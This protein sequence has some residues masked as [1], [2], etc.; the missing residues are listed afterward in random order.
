MEV[1]ENQRY[2]RPHRGRNSTTQDKGKSPMEE[3]EPSKKARVRAK[4]RKIGMEDFFL[5]EGNDPY[6]LLD[7]LKEKKADITYGQLMQL[8]SSVR[9]Q[10]HEVA[11]VHRVK[12]KDPKLHV[13]QMTCVADI[14]PLVADVWIQDRQVQKAYVDGGAQVCVTTESTMHHLKVIGKSLFSVRMANSERVK[15]LGVVKDLDVNVLGHKATM[16]IHVMPAK[17]GSY[18]IILGRPWLIATK[19][20]RDWYR[21]YLDLFVDHPKG[22]T[23]RYNMKIG[24]VVEIEED[25][26]SESLGKEDLSTSN[27]IDYDSEEEAYDQSLL[28]LDADVCFLQ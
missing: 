13:V 9:R 2:A 10:W 23:I 1:E 15:C 11:S 22:E 19:L 16:D 21:G 26:N 14:Q 24:R 25:S 8:S 5:G 17:I 3:G 12:M 18:P 27:I 6:N 7:D 20:R 28:E 4:K